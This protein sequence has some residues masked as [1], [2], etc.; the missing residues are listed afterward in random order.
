MKRYLSIWFPNWPLTRLSRIKSGAPQPAFAPSKPFALVENGPHGLTVA[1]AN[2]S[3]RN[4]GVTEG[5]RL[6]DARARAPALL[7]QEI[8]RKADHAALL[9]LAFWMI[10]V[11]PIVTIDNRDGLIIETT[12][13]ERYYGGERALLD[14]IKKLLEQNSIPHQLAVA[15]TPGA[16][17]ALARYKPGVALQPNTLKDG[18]KDI[19][20]AGLRLSEEALVLLRRFGLTRIG[21]LYDIDR[22]ALARRFR[23]KDMAEAVLVRLDQALGHRNEPIIPVIPP[24][25]FAARLPCPEPVSNSEALLI[26]LDRL[27]EDLCAQLKTNCQGAQLFTFHAFRAD[28]GRDCVDIATARPSAA[29]DHIT[30]LFHEKIDQIN[31]GFGIDLLLLHARRTGPLEIISPALSGDLA[32]TK[33]DERQTAELVDRL[34]A[35]LGAD[36]V[37]VSAFRARHLPEKA[38]ERK[39]YGG[40]QYKDA[41]APSACGPRPQRLIDPPEPIKA[42][43]EVPDGPPRAFQWRRVRRRV[44]K[45]D[46]PERLAPEWWRHTTPV[47]L[48][49]PSDKIA[50][51]WLTPKM[52]PRADAAQ[53][54]KARSEIEAAL[55]KDMGEPVAKSPRARDYYRVEDQ[56]GR[57]YW[58]YRE[59]LY[60]DG[61]GA[62]P[63]WFIHGLFS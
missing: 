30:R 29:A 35:K 28:G 19:E 39:P 63:Q 56:D 40:A 18:L 43:A 47:T 62:T 6:A 46:G 33:A 20:C 16:A 4:Y 26:G 15:G 59:G 50:R 54:R 8:D 49:S 36:S 2:A 14:H 37:R 22:K 61:R 38:E 45:A 13:C 23:S 21:H 11:A 41:P 60:D 53:I 52:D 25:R 12:G 55:L 7:S 10:R 1:A 57:R 32:G 31:P 3:A 58:L 48:A 17:H 42:L 51:K 27:A 9:M 34:S 24:P 5:L 44:V